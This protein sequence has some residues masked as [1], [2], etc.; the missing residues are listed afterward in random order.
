[1]PEASL[2][3][4]HYSDIEKAY[5]DPMRLGR[6]AGLIGE[7]RTEETLVVG[8][9]DNIAPS[10]LSLLT[11]GAQS[12]DFFEHVHPDAETFGNHDF[13]PGIEATRRVVRESPQQWLN[14]NLK[15]N[16]EWFATHE[17][18]EPYA[19]VESGTVR[20]GLLG[21]TTPDLPTMNANASSLTV[22]DPLETVEVLADRLRTVYDVDYVVV[23]SHL[24]TEET[25]VESLTTDVDAVLGG[26]SHEATAECLDGTVVSRPQ[27]NGERL[28]EV[29]LGETPEVRLL[30]LD[31]APVD[32]RVRDSVRDRITATGLDEVLCTVDEPLARTKLTASRGE[33]RIGNFVTD[34]YR[35]KTGADIAVLAARAIRTDAHLAGDVTVYDVVSLVPFD[36]P[37]VVVELSGAELRQTLRELDHRGRPETLPNWSFGHLSGARVTWNADRTIADATVDGTPITPEETYTLATTG[38]Y[39]ETDH[40]FTAFDESAILN[41][42]GPQYEALIQYARDADV[43]PTIE[44][45][46]V[47]PDEGNS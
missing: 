16:D 21:V 13:D 39:V 5:D 35:W 46:I 43:E 27:A 37:L 14:S 29:V 25:L 42:L 10:V 34:A 1:M 7:R 26:H 31:T 23:L 8:T 17:G 38:Y 18:A 40:I 19:V 15:E 11:D 22:T 36:E 47:R 4:L 2:R 6:L 24:G 45:R 28:L 20:V 33:S 9:G 3:I 32:T 30:D 12:L 41:S 44:G